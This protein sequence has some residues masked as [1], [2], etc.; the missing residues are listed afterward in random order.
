MAFWSDQKSAEPAR[1][2][3]WYM[4][5]MSPAGA[6]S[7]S[8]IEKYT[9]ALKECSKPESKIE[10]SDHYLLN[11][12]KRFPKRLS[13]TPINVKMVA[14][15]K[16]Q[17]TLEES[18]N[19]LIINGEINSTDSAL[20]RGFSKNQLMLSSVEIFQ[21]FDTGQPSDSWSLINPWI[22]S[23][24]YGSL[25]Y[26][27]EGFVEV[28]FQIVYDNAIYKFYN[29][30]DDLDYYTQTVERVNEVRESGVELYEPES[31]AD[32]A[33]RIDNSKEAA[34]KL[35]EATK[36]KAKMTVA[37]PTGDKFK[38]EREA[39][40]KEYKELEK[41]AEAAQKRLDKDLTEAEGRRLVQD[42]EA[43][44]QQRAEQR[45][46][47]G[48]RQ[49]LDATGEYHANQA[50][51]RFQQQQAADAQRL[52]QER[53]NASQR[54]HTQGPLDATGAYQANQ[55]NSRYQ[56]QQAAEAQRLQQETQ[57]ASQHS[58]TRGPLKPPDPPAP[59]TVKRAGGGGDYPVGNND[60][61]A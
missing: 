16:N 54:S 51:L 3:R 53:Q 26:E 42:L 6:G 9:F 21:L 22:T 32:P 58:H 35:Q 29:I 2:H 36:A 49:T 30:P 11:D 43:Q 18:L 14:A 37:N 55:A 27:N 52:E 56:Q 41:K 47:G 39:K 45:A 13:W 46:R 50:E 24:N 15:R 4:R 33:I 31:I 19:L 17:S 57:N 61:T 25:S 8:P 1:Q 44:K 48:D 40:E 38:K 10:Y 59:T 60:D 20:Y 12:L 5:I 7:I 34:A 28:S 23:I